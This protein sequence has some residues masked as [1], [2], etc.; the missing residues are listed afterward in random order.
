MGILNDMETTLKNGDQ[1][2]RL[3]EEKEDLIFDLL[4][5][6]V[7]RVVTS[8]NL[9]E[10]LKSSLEKAAFPLLSKYKSREIVTLD[11]TALTRKDTYGMMA[12]VAEKVK[13]SPSL[14]VVIN[15]ITGVWT[16]PNCEDPQ[17]V[18]NLVGHSWKNEQI[19]FGDYHIDRSEMTVIFTST[20]TTQSELAQKYRLDSYAWLDDFDTKFNAIQ[21]LLDNLK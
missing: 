18:E 5:P 11:C 17:Y 9:C 19:Y 8:N 21:Q 7:T 15:N 3:L 20:P 13:K 4:I 10:I 2:C 16:D 14:I 6:G 12:L 1:I